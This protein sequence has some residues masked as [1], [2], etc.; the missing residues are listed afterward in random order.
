M[1]QHNETTDVRDL[2]RNLS[3][4]DFLN[5]GVSQIAYVREVEVENKPAFAIYGA[6][7]SQ[8]NI[9]ETT[10]GAA[11]LLIQNDLEPITVH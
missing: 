10:D 6:D 3:R 4:Q 8:I 9:A 2:M 11:S 7:G 5:L 1:T